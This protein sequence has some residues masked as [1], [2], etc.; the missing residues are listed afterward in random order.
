MHVIF[1]DE[2]IQCTQ[3]VTNVRIQIAGDHDIYTGNNEYDMWLPIPNTFIV[4]NTD[5]VQGFG[6]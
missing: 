1:G 4:A 6:C 2:I 3:V 5:M